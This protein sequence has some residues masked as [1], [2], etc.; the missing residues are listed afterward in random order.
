[1]LDLTRE[2][3]RHPFFVSHMTSTVK[4]IVDSLPLAIKKQDNFWTVGSASYKDRG[5]RTKH[6]YDL[7]VAE[8][9]EQ[10]LHIFPHFYRFLLEFFSH[11][12]DSHC[13]FMPD[14]SIPGFH[15]FKY[16]KEFEKP[17]ARPHVDAPFNLFDWGKRVGT[18]N[19]F[20][21]VVPLEIPENAGMYVWDIKAEEI[22]EKGWEHVKQ[23]AETEDYAGLIK[24]HVD[25]MVVHS[26]LYLHQIKPFDGPTKEWRITLQLHAVKMDDIWRLYW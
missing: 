3:I 4:N 9:N 10:L 24:Y 11:T 22:Q 16:C 19:L 2:F 25:Q 7:F 15:V 6:E 21:A 12:L 13:E 1:M 20:T 5:V 23:R 14:V 8:K 26:G 17:L 18:D